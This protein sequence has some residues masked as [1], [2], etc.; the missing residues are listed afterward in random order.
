MSL[1]QEVRQS[2]AQSAAQ[3]SSDWKEPA[4]V[5][6]L[7]LMSSAIQWVTGS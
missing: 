5:T 2:G 6:I 3:P 1:S 4:A 7:L